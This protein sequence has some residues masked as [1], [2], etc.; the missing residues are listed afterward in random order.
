ML[1]ILVQ[2]F[3][4]F[5]ICR[6]RSFIQQKHYWII[7]TFFSV[8][9]FDS[10]SLRSFSQ[11]CLCG[12]PMHIFSIYCFLSILAFLPPSLLS[13]FSP[14]LLPFPFF[15]FCSFFTSIS[16]WSLPSFFIVLLIFSILP[17]ALLNF[18]F[19]VLSWLFL[20]YFFPEFC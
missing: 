11:I 4:V 6:F 15:C 8:Y 7:T 1:I 20:L 10:F 14:S 9:L 5:P 18:V 3:W 13:F 2:F 16:M 12:S 19:I 17:Y